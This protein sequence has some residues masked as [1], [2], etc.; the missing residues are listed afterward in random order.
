MQPGCFSVVLLSQSDYLS[1]NS[2]IAWLLFSMGFS[3][4]AS[5]SGVHLRSFTL[6]SCCVTRTALTDQFLLPVSVMEILTE[7]TKAK[8][9]L[10]LTKNKNCTLKPAYFC[11]VYLIP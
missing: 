10:L 1:H 4:K 3:V 8:S 2:Q 9:P 5:K 11:L 7:S 6:H